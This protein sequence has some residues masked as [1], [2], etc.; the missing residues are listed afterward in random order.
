M[1][2]LEAST[3]KMRDEGVGDA[4]VHAFADAY[5]RLRGGETGLLPEAEIEPV[6]ELPDAEGEELE[7][8]VEGHAR[9]LQVDGER[10]FGSLP[11][12]ERLAAGAGDHVVVRARRLDGPLWEVDVAE[13]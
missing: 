5:E 3:Q 10:A 2:G 8:T 4:A 11:E 6:E 13:L 12:L 1:G 9:V 7:L